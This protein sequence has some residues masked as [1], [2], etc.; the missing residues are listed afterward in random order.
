[1][2]C[3]YGVCSVPPRATRSALQLERLDR[4]A[5]QR[6]RSSI[7]GENDEV[8]RC[9]SAVANKPE[10]VR[11]VVPQAGRRATGLADASQQGSPFVVPTGFEPVSPP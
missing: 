9:I 3:T 7:L 4:R 8:M 11:I 5:Y 10:P 1:M 6:K 2:T